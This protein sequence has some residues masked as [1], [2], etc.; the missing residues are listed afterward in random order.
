MRTFINETITTTVSAAEIIP[1]AKKCLEDIKRIQEEHNQRYL[2]EYMEAYNSNWKNK[3]FKKSLKDIEETKKHVILEQEKR[4]ENDRWGFYFPI[5]PSYAYGDLE[6]RANEIIIH[7]NNAIE[8][9]PYTIPVSIYN[10]IALMA[11]PL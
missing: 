11:K 9:T 2:E 3:L 10:E 7:F 6:S 1:L 5:Y 4:I 8:K